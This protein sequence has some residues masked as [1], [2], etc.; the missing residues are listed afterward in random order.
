MGSLLILAANLAPLIRRHIA[1][2][3]LHA[4]A[5]FVTRLLFFSLVAVGNM[6]GVQLAGAVLVHVAVHID[7]PRSSERFFTRQVFES[8]FV[9]QSSSLD[10]FNGANLI[11]IRSAAAHSHRAD[12]FVH[13]HD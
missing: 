3:Y 8:N 7:S 5:R 1:H 6:H 9:S 10:S 11:L 4:V 13:I 2:V 12:N